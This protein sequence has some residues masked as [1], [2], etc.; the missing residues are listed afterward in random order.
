MKRYYHSTHARYHS[1]SSANYE[2]SLR[3]RV[4]QNCSD[5]SELGPIHGH[6]AQAT[7]HLPQ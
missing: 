6:R 1:T 4:M 5:H 7:P 3:L 2:V